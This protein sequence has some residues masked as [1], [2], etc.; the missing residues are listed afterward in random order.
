V[1][2]TIN[3]ALAEKHRATIRAIVL[4]HFHADFV[5]GHLEL[6]RLTQAPIYLGAGAQA[7]YEFIAATED[8]T[9]SL[10]DV[11]L[12]FL[13]TPGHTP[14]S[15]CVLV[16]DDQRHREEPVAVFTGDTLFIGDVGRPDLM[17]SVGT[18]AAEMASQMYDSLHK[19]LLLLP[20]DTLVYPGHGA[21]SMCGK[22]L[23][24]ERSSTIG[25][26]RQMNFALQIPTRAGFVASL[27]AAQPATP[28]YFAHD[29][30]MNRQVHDVLEDVLHRA[31]RPL[32]V[33]ELLD[34][35][36]AGALLLDVRPGKEYTAAHLY[37]SFHVGLDGNFATWCGTLLESNT[38]IVLIAVDGQE[39]E[40]AMRLGRI[41]YDNVLGYLDGGVESLESRPDLL[42]HTSQ[43]TAQ[44]LSERLAGNEPPQIVDVRTGEEWEQAHVLGSVHIPLGELAERLDDVPRNSN[45]VVHCATG[46]RSLVAASILERNGFTNFSDLA[47]GYLA[48]DLTRV[49]G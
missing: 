40:A 3:L 14:E 2:T 47:G 29:A 1:A 46:Y 6:Q 19:K 17:A 33:E 39:G 42:R 27:T 21:G 31:L 45:F 7:E 37:G 44:A 12:R 18:T 10:G 34:R 9:V 49:E 13:Q 25:Q 48:W 23:S 26:Q 22:N 35:R 20:D 38:A 16:H 11:R 28:N 43:I 4:T 41:G 30:R 32:S 24:A 15:V 5:S 36:A 8:V